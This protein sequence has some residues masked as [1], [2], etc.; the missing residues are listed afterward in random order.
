[1]LLILASCGKPFVKKAPKDKFYLYKN[2]ITVTGGAFS[3]TERYNLTQRLYDQLEDNSKVVIS[4]NVL[5]FK[6][7]NNP[8]IYDSSFTRLSAQNIKFTLFHLG[9]YNSKVDF[10]TDT[11][12]KKIIVYYHA[13][14]GNPTLIDSVNYQ[15]NY[16][17]LS[18]YNNNFK[19]ESYFKKNTPISK[20]AVLADINRVVD[21]FK[22][23][24]FYKITPAEI[25]VLGDTT[26]EALSSITDDPFE[27]LKKL[28]NAQQK[29]DSPK[30]KLSIELV[31]PKDSSRLKQYTIHNINI[32]PN[33]SSK[34]TESAPIKTSENKYFR[35]FEKKPI[36]HHDIFEK[37][38]S[39]RTG[40]IYK[41]SDF[42]ESIYKL[43]KIGVW[44]N[45]NIQMEDDPE[46]DSMVNI[47]IKLPP[48][49]KYGFENSLEVSYSAANNNSSVLAGNLFG[50]SENISISNRNLF[51]EGIRMTHNFRAG[52]E[53]N[54]NSTGSDN[55]INSNEISYENTTIFPKL[56]LSNIPYLFDKTKDDRRGQTFINLGANY[57]T[58]LNL[59][60]LLTSNAGFGWNG[61]NVK[62]WDWS[63]SFIKFGF[64]NLYNQSDSFQTIVE[65]NPFLKFSFNT[66]F[67]NGMGISFYKNF[68]SF[69]VRNAETR[70]LALR[71]NAEE[72][73]LTWG[74]LPIINKYKRRFIKTD[75]EL[76]YN[77]KYH[78]TSLS[79][80]GFAGIGIPLL[81]S[82]SN[83]TLPFFKQ[84][85]AGGSN[86]MRGW[87]VRGI[88]PGGKSLIPYNSNGNVF[89]DR[90][91]DIQFELNGEYR[92]DILK[93]IPNTLTLRGAVFLDIGN[94]WNMNNTKFDGS[95]DSSQFT[96]KNFYSQLGVS[97]GTGLRLDFNYFVVRFDFGFRFKRPELF[98]QND[99]WKAPDISFSDCLNKM[100]ARGTDDEYTKWR[101]ENFNF[102]IG[103]GYPF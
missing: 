18:D 23:N 80:R 20:I 82:D 2:N 60:N 99:G 25:K 91:G 69:P 40:N 38:I 19:K 97:A 79:F 93:I 63:W 41:Q 7:I 53:L 68:T 33:Y 12:G 94:I 24:G 92:Y 28:A 45:I 10:K 76:K 86:S 103:I 3:K 13:I 78:K 101:Y 64:S 35:F 43:N 67:V 27:Q 58:R 51:K 49:K 81:G 100:F 73:G 48:S 89:N 62:G 29:I 83:K 14:C 66:A 90:T 15:F 17:K 32:W 50:I 9:F 65:Q 57:I 4:Q 39:F 1:M 70:E 44:Q 11:I 77:I 8:Q 6:F 72:S 34:D 85:F 55:F 98:Y 59:F 47:F 36:L 31:I 5:F 74:L 37:L 42:N 61:K 71:I 52:I 46:Q 30:I 95:A 84:Y 87:S 102:S 56:I 75:A 16:N 88:G 96:L 22:N 54:N 26:I 21:S